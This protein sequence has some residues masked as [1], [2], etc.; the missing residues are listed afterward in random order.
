MKGVLEKN[1]YLSYPIRCN[2]ISE[3]VYKLSIAC[4]GLLGL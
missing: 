4:M 3:E 2:D 1:I